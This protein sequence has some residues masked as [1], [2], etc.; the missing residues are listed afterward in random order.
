MP[1]VFDVRKGLGVGDNIAIRLGENIKFFKVLARD[2]ILF[3]QEG[4]A[5]ASDGT[6]TFAEVTA[7][8]PPDDELYQ[9]FR[10]DLLEGNV[11]VQFKQPASTNRFVVTISS[12]DGEGLPDG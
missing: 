9:F 7:L 8:N 3:E 4:S 6:S 5:I 11:L 1:N 12:S 2:L 10:F